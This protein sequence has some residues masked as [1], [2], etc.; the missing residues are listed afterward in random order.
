MFRDKLINGATKLG[1]DNQLRSMRATLLPRYRHD[2]VENE[3]VRKLLESILREDSN[4]IDIGAYR[5]RILEELVRIAPR[6]KHIAYE[7]LPHLYKYLVE[8]FPSVDVRQAAVSNE[9]GETNFIY[10]KNIPAE[11]GFSE[12]SHGRQGQIEKLTVRTEAL[13]R[14]LPAGYAPAL[15]KVDVEGAERQVFEGAIGTISKY[16]PIIIFEHGKGGAAH[17]ET[18]PRHIYELLNEVAGLRIFD[19]DGN[20]PYTLGQ[21]EETYARDERWDYVA[22]P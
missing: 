2:R 14:C 22:R 1:I 8:H 11:S 15:I 9:I 21:L 7:P 12:R 5:G 20:G 17:Y 18:E 19:L 3:H 13:D 10:V 4:C 6:G 16:K